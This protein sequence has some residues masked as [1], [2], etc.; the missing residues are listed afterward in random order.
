MRNRHGAVD[1]LLGERDHFRFLAAVCAG[2]KVYASGMSYLLMRVLWIA[3]IVH[4]VAD[5]PCFGL[6]GLFALDFLND[7][8]GWL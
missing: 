4:K 3:D 1:A 5:L 2:E 8:G 6:V 7:H